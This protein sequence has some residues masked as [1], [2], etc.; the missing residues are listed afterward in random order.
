MMTGFTAPS[1]LSRNCFP[2]LI[3]SFAMTFCVQ[4]ETSWTPKMPLD[5]LH[6][7]T[8]MRQITGYFDQYLMESTWN[9]KTLQYVK[10]HYKQPFLGRHQ[11]F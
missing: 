5:F 4:T 6:S 1:L 11:N 3:R 10:E 7:K 8:P 9:Y 2:L